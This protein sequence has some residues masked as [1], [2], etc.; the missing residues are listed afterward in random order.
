MAILST[1]KRLLLRSWEVIARVYAAAFII[2]LLWIVHVI[3]L[4]ELLQ[5]P[6]YVLLLVSLGEVMLSGWT[7]CVHTPESPKVI[8]PV[9]R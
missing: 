8:D 9:D 5:I 2:I 3:A 4:P 6:L 1:L 7:L